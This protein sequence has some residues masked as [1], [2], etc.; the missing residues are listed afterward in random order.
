MLITGPTSSGKT[1]LVHKIVQKGDVIVNLDVQQFYKRLNVGISKPSFYYLKKFNYQLVD[2]LNLDANYSC[3]HFLQAL[4]KVIAR[5][6]TSKIYLVGGSSLYQRVVTDGLGKANETKLGIKEKLLQEYQAGEIENLLKE[7]KVKD[8]ECY[9]QIDRKNPQRVL[10]ALEVIRNGEKFSKV[11]KDKKKNNLEI[12]KITLL[13]PRKR[14]YSNINQTIEKMFERKWLKEVEKLIKSIG[15]DKVYNIKAIGYREIADFIL[16]KN[17]SLEELKAKIKQKT[18]KYAKQQLTW[19]K[20]KLI[21]LVFYD[22]NGKEATISD[23]DD[24]LDNWILKHYSNNQSKFIFNP[25]QLNNEVEKFFA[26]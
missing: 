7:L 10:R 18:R 14:L 4:E 21:G 22:K 11:R 8:P 1:S 26:S 15:V 5:N 12:L 23:Y 19:F 3:F 17:L 20:K 16:E 6:K 9:E 25:K 13:P 24:T 2:F